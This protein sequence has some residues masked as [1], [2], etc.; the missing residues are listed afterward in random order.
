M[1]DG[2]DITPLFQIFGIRIILESKD[3]DFPGECVDLVNM[4]DNIYFSA[5]KCIQV[6]ATDQLLWGLLYTAMGTMEQTPPAL[7]PPAKN[8]RIKPCSWKR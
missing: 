4:K 7:A 8:L 6:I 1:E 3:K 5:R 2:G